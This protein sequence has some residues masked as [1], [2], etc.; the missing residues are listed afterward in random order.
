MT[1]SFLLSEDL[2]NQ[3]SDVS[4]FPQVESLFQVGVPVGTF[5]DFSKEQAT[6]AAADQSP[7]LVVPLMVP[8]RLSVQDVAYRETTH[9]GSAIAEARRSS[10]TSSEAGCR[11][12]VLLEELAASSEGVADQLPYRCILMPGLSSILEGVS[13]APAEVASATTLRP[14][15]P[16]SH[17]GLAI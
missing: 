7:R 15:G 9:R 16:A 14:D 2:G 6:A 10:K 13:N 3:N 1:A 12:E 4:Q 5:R 8:S 17:T 11:P